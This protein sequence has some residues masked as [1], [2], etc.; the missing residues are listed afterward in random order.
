MEEFRPSLIFG[1]LVLYLSACLGVGIWS[2][3]RT[4]TPSDFFM[5]GRSLGPW[6][7]GLAVFSSNLSGFAF[8]GNPG[9]IYAFGAGAIWLPL[10]GTTAYAL[11]F[12]TL[13]KRLRM[14][15][16][17]RNTLSLPDVVA[18]RYQSDLTRGLT[19]L[20]ILLGTVKMY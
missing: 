11:A 1:A 2:I 16:E 8:V 17:I 6:V 20:A 7:T 5:A 19:A 13:A 4:R 15:A 18:V 3:G 10:A 14:I 12:C 9:L